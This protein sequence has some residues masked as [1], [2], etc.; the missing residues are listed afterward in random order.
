MNRR[1]TICLFLGLLT[2]LFYLPTE[3]VKNQQN[4]V[5]TIPVEVYWGEV[6]E[7]LAVIES[8][9]PRDADAVHTTLDSLALEFSHITAVELANGQQIPLSNDYLMFLFNESEPDLGRLEIYLETM[10]NTRERWPDPSHDNRDLVPLS[11]ILARP[12]FQ[13]ALQEPGAL[14]GIWQRVTDALVEQLAE[15]FPDSGVN[16]GPLVRIVFTAAASIA[17]AAVIFFALRDILSD[18]VADSAVS[19]AGDGSQQPISADRALEQAQTLSSSGDYRMAARYLYLGSL[20]MLEERGMLRYDRT[21]TNQEYLRSVAGNPELAAVLRDVIDVFD[22]VWYGYQPLD[23]K[24]F[25]HYA[26][27]VEELRH[28]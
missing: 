22:R 26:K 19:P 21:Q 17:L 15:I 16:F 27:R 13:S 23:D 7:A 25:S 18:M 6:A 5:G 9:Q 2:F 3:D 28:Q 8:L 12:E 11:A 14:E 10:L 24:A 1:G 4:T 20:L